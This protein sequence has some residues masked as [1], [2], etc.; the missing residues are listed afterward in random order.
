MTWLTI[1]RLHLGL[2]A[3][4]WT[5]TVVTAALADGGGQKIVSLGGSVTEIVVALGAGDRLIGR[6]ST[7][8]WPA[9]VTALP[10]VGYLRA[11]SA[12]GVL[13]LGPDLVLAEADAGPPEAVEALRA[14][15]LPFVT[16]PG[17][18]DHQGI[19]DKIEA[20]AAALALP[21]E[22][23]ALAEHV[24]AGL[25]EAEARAAAV[26][27]PQRVLFILSLQGG[28]IM[29][30][31]EE[32]S[33]EGIIELAGGRN[34]LTGIRGYRQITDEAVVAAAPD[35]ILMMD[36]EGDLAIVDAEVLAHP[37]L[38]TTPAARDGR[39]L[40]MDGLLLL[41]FGP[42]TPEAAGRLHAAL[43]PEGP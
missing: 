23:K 5:L 8:T 14:A 15:G 28:R 34:A 10:D 39:I 11:L 22:G 2:A 26:E 3:M 37:A 38:A 25:A 13:A 36:R 29:A 40:R 35:V 27:A 9:E 20:V 18:P 43:Y 12:E 33:A 24:E 41:G 19:V 1:G 30:A 17:S 32:T 31:G 16:L 21:A 6:D 42:R 7:S 4:L